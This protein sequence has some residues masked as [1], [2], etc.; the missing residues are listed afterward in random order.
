MPRLLSVGLV[1]VALIGSAAFAG[2]P[3]RAAAPGARS[4]AAASAVCLHP[5]GRPTKWREAADT[6]AVS[7][8]AKARVA[9][10]VR[11]A[12]RAA[13][14]RSALQSALPGAPSDTRATAPGQIVVPVFIHV[15]HGTKK[16]ERRIGR[17]AARRMFRT[18]K[19]GYAGRQNPA[20]GATSIRFRL[21][22]IT[23]SR[24]SAW[25]HAPPYS[26]AD[27]QMK[28][29]LHRGTARVL[30]LY[31]NRPRAQGQMLLGFST[32]PWQRARRP[33]LDGVTVSDVSLPH[34]RARGYNLG[35][36][37]I[38]ETGHWLGLLHTFEGG[39]DGGDKVADTPAEAVPSFHC[40]EGRNTC[41]VDPVTGAVVDDG[42]PDPIHNFMDYSYDFCMNSFTPGQNELMVASYMHFR[43]KR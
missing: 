18:L 7:E 12:R 15:I 39:C 32:F 20:A 23:I 21:R 2:S 26:R 13:S 30:N 24:N 33:K 1:A 10:L 38:H 8:R 40:D 6:S 28:N 11:S 43:Y 31:V 34:G 4:T 41:P 19:D 29:R 14:A 3:A 17:H 35:D 22:K 9:S 36:T 16:S 5:A 25:F 42:L 37:V 27:V